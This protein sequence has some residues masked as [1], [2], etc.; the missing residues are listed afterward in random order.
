MEGARTA[1]GGR[2]LDLGE[3]EEVLFEREHVVL[4]SARLMANW[5]G[6]GARDV[7]ALRDVDG[8]RRLDGGQESRMGAGLRVLAGAAALAAVQVPIDALLISRSQV[9][10]GVDIVNTLMFVAWALAAGVAAYLIITSVFRVRPHTSL[11]FVRFRDKDV[12]V[13]FPGRNN[14]DAALL[15]AAFERQMRSRPL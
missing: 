13:S 2:R 6:E 1:A 7:V 12:L 14:P 3:S 8:V 15:R 9:H 4:T 11:L 10:I 5:S